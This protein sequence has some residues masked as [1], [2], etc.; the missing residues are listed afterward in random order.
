[1]KVAVQAII[2]I[3]KEIRTLKLSEEM[4]K[5]RIFASD[6]D[7]AAVARWLRKQAGRGFL[8][9]HGNEQANERYAQQCSAR[10]ELPTAPNSVS[11]ILTRDYFATSVDGWHLTIACVT[12]SSGFRPYVPEE[13]DLWLDLIFGPYRGRA[14]DETA[15]I[16][17]IV[18]AMKG[19]R[20]FRLGALKGLR[21]FRLPVNWSDRSDPAVTLE[22]S[23]NPAAKA[24]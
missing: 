1:M 14:I 9:G 8:R 20:N 6:Y 23:T 17:S 15:D 21:N 16:R 12:T 19:V 3:Q 10:V 13:G 11:L 2:H 22:F 24:E 4:I 5:G 18:G 7:H